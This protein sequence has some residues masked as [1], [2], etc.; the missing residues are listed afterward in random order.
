[1]VVITM[2][3][4]SLLTKLFVLLV[5]CFHLPLTQA[6]ERVV[7][8]A[9]GLT[10]RW[11]VGNGPVGHYCYPYAPALQAQRQNIG[12][13]VFFTRAQLITGNV[14]LETKLYTDYAW[15]ARYIVEISYVNCV[16]F[17]YFW[18]N[19]LAM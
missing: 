12:A 5:H 15:I 14:K 11:F 2:L 13:K 4:L 10:N 17:S 18:C 19:G 7:D 3:N 9:V 8:R 6:G 1:M 16:V